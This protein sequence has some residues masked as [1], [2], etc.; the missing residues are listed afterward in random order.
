MNCQGC[1]ASL[2]GLPA[3]FK[4]CRKCFAAEKRQEDIDTAYQ[5]GY[6]AGLAAGSIDGARLRQLIQL[7]HPDRH[8]GSRAATDVTKW[9][10]SMRREAA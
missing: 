4:K 10:L 7:C 2:V 3:Y 9:L 8:A 1:G 6:Q 5:T